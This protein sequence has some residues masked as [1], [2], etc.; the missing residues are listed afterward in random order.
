MVDGKLSVGL[1]LFCMIFFPSVLTVLKTRVPTELAFVPQRIPGMPPRG[2][3]GVEAPLLIRCSEVGKRLEDRRF[4]TA[5]LGDK[6]QRIRLGRIESISA[7]T[8]AIR[9]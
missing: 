6:V 1:T 9:T 2:Q 8:N 3:N 7:I 5:L 4:I